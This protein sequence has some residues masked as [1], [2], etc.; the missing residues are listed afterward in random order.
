VM[1]IPK[2]A[3]R[4][5]VSL[6]VLSTKPATGIGVAGVLSRICDSDWR[7]LLCRWNRIKQHQL[8]ASAMENAS[9]CSVTVD[10][11]SGGMLARVSEK[12]C[13]RKP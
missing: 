1:P 12:D 10:A 8:A 13:I 6:C 9:L 11:G 2:T 4:R 3:I 5:I 7:R